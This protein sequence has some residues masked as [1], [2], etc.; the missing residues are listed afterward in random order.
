M[1]KIL[2]NEEKLKRAK[3]EIKKIKN[4]IFKKNKEALK[5][6][7]IAMGNLVL[8]TK[9]ENFYKF[10]TREEIKKISLINDDYERIKQMF[11]VFKKHYE[12][13]K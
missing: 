1:P 6:E 9:T 2:T 11:L 3:E 7:K 8:K 5:K 4:D 10:L 13:N 12:M